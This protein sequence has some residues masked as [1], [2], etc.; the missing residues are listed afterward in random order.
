MADKRIEWRP[1]ELGRDVT[2]K[3]LKVIVNQIGKDHVLETHGLIEQWHLLGLL[4][5]PSHIR[6]CEGVEVS[7]LPPVWD[8]DRIRAELNEFSAQHKNDWEAGFEL[9]MKM[10]K[11]YKVASAA[12]R[13]ELVA[14]IGEEI[15]RVE[16]RNSGEEF[17][18]GRNRY[19]ELTGQEYGEG[20]DEDE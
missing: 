15:G 17:T 20:G 11:E 14:Y 9:A 19:R 16:W 1:L 10:S 2:G 4:K 18:W 6:L 8:E 7:A 12:L 13:D 5:L 3:R